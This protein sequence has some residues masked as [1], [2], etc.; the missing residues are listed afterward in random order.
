M[1]IA[2]LTDGGQRAE[3]VA[4]RLAS[5]LRA[6]R[7]SIDLA[8]YSV[9]IPGPVGGELAAVL[10][11][12]SARGIAVRAVVQHPD[13]KPTPLHGTV[14]PRTRPE[15]LRRLGVQ[16]RTIAPERALMHHKFAVRDGTALWTGST[17]WTLADWTTEE[18]VIVQAESP[19]LATVYMQVF[20]QLWE[21]G[22]IDDSGAIEA[23][24]VRLDGGPVRPWFCPAQGRDL[25]QRIAEHVAGARTRLRIASPVITAGP[26]L[27]ALDDVRAAGTTDASGIVDLTQTHA[28]LGQWHA[29]GAHW[30]APVLER[31]L[32]SLRFAGKSSTP[33]DGTPGVRHD[34]MHA[35]V[36]VADDTVFVGSF[37]LS[38]SGE[39]NAENVLEIQSRTLAD[40]MAGYVDALRARYPPAA[41]GP[42]AA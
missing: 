3:D 33:F 26:V 30:K 35:K 20:E 42:A 15:L 16:I 13:V 4:A 41:P 1:R 32:D 10:R 40:Q 9:R 31:V 27:R 37:N 8:L 34:T 12:A 2:G 19:E 17:N 14:A 39:D 25:S 29:L 6:A 18:N 21:N 5:W 24:P 28:V 36:V 11:D 38:R 7:S 23:P 22:T